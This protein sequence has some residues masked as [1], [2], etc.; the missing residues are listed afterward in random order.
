M[1][2][3]E[4]NKAGTRR[5]ISDD[6]TARIYHTEYKC[7]GC[8]TWLHEDEVIWATTDGVLNTDLGNAYCDSCLPKEE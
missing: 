1:I 6:M 7:F 3:I 5:T 8:G 4:E 2:H